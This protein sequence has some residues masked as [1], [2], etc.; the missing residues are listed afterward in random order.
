MKHLLIN[1]GCAILVFAGGWLVARKRNNKQNT[2]GDSWFKIIFSNNKD[3]DTTISIMWEY[4]IYAGVIF[5][6]FIL[7]FC[8]RFYFK[9]EG[10]PNG[11]LTEALIHSIV[12]YNVGFIQG[13]KKREKTET[14]NSQNEQLTK[15][16]GS[17]K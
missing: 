9:G 7:E 6:L 1:I 15:N 8:I 16:G 17:R 2:N 14:T 10:N 13:S 4:F 3:F 5:G 11:I 12:A